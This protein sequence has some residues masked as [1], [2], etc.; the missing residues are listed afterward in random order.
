ML[1]VSELVSNIKGIFTEVYQT[2]PFTR[3]FF[4]FS[5][6]WKGMMTLF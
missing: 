6:R 5:R 3:L 2:F 1:N 4:S